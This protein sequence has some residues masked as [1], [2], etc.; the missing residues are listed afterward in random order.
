MGH[1]LTREST[2]R[3][4]WRWSLACLALLVV[5][6]GFIEPHPHFGIDAIFAFPAWYGFLAC[7]ALI[8]IAKAIG[9]FIKRPDT[10]YP[11]EQERDRE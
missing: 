10:Y 4:L 3:Q 6:G 8:V 9:L 2:I 5:I 7:I 11:A 1:W